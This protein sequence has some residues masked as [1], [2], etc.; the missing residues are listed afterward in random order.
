MK[1]IYILL[2]G[3]VTTIFIGCKAN[4]NSIMEKGI[5][6]EENLGSTNNKRKQ[7]SE[8]KNSIDLI[9]RKVNEV[10]GDYKDNVAIYFK[11]LNTNE[12]Y[13]LNEN[14]YYVAASTNKVPLSMLILDEVNRGE[15][16]LDD[17]LYFIEEDREIGS[18]LL[19]DLEEVPNLTINEAI[20]LSIVNS[21]NIAKNMLIRVA[22][23]DITDYMKEI[24]QDNSIPYGNYLTARQLGILLNK[25]YENPD[26]NPYY[27]QLIE[28]M[29]ETTYHDRLDKYLDYDKVA[30]K[31]GNY[32][33]YYHDIGIIYGEDPYI[34]VVLTKDIGDLSTEPYE[35]GGENERY[36]LDWGEEAFE[37]IASLSR[38]IYTI[39][40]ESKR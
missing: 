34:L 36:L 32:Y 8:S 22:K 30:H 33:R 28:Y 12:E 7:V 35:E 40:E 23:N 5:S 39:V 6:N 26:N 19:Y 14:T 13:T 37:L 38:E 17:L 27:N 1:K 3:I 25:L 15:K 31:I 10:L 24:T 18:G 21:D 11:N 29:T 16:S 20:Y 4:D 9:D 2:L